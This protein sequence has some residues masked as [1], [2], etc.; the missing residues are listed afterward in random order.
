MSLIRTVGLYHRFP[1]RTLA[2]RGIDLQVEEGEL[3]LVA[4]RN[5]S[6]KTVLMRHLNGLLRPTEGEVLLDERPIEEDLPAAR[7]KV[8]LVFQDPDSQLIGQT[9]REEVAFGPENLKLPRE[10]VDRR[11]QDS[12]AAVGLSHL[13]DHVPRRLSGGEKR[14][15]AVAGVLVMEPRVIIFDEPFS[16]LD[17]PGVRQLLGEIV[18]L[19]REGHTIILITHE[20][21]KVLG[22]ATRMVLM[23]EGRIVGSGRPGEL[24]DC[25]EPHGIRRPPLNGGGVEGVSW[26]R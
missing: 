20:I 14:R 19:H 3:L 5:G 6:G 24:L 1:D 25:L 23:D 12:L 13:A 18:R 26:L 22:H 4:G 10:E 9:V 7:R 2:L 8:G 17:Y 11:V 21:E 16:G 15:L